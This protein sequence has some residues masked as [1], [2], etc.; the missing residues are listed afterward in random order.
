L[1]WSDFDENYVHIRRAM[2]RGVVSS[3]K[4]VRSIRSIPLIQ[5]VRRLLM[6]WR[7]KAG[8]GCGVFSNPEGNPLRM[9]W[10]ANNIIKPALTREKLEWKGFHAGRR[11]FGAVMRQLT[12]NS[13]TARDLLGH[14]TTRVPEQHYEGKVPEEA[15]RGMKLLEAK[16][17]KQ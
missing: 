15:L 10:V 16:V 7:S 14:T 5:P 1:Q 11:G 13:K 9:D 4:T 6:L 2:G 3:P 17:V 8:D 12:G